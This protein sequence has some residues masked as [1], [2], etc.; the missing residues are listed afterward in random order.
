MHDKT[1]IARVM[2]AIGFAP[3]SK[4]GAHLGLTMS[5]TDTSLGVRG[6]D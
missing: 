5:G 6:F 4:T 2:E 1:Y 3:E